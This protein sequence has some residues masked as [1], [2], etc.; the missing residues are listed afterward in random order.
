MKRIAVTAFA[1]LC[2]AGPAAAAPID[3][4]PGPYEAKY[5]NVEGF[6]TTAGT[7]CLT[8]TTDCEN[9]GVLEL[10][11][12][13]P[14]PILGQ[15]PWFELSTSGEITAYFYDIA[16]DQII[17]GP[18]G[19]D[20]GTDPDSFTVNSTGGFLDIYWDDTEDFNGSVA[21]VTDGTLMVRFAF[22]PG[23]LP[24][25]L[26][27]VSGSVN[28]LTSPLSG[29][30]SAYLAVVAGSGPWAAFFDG[31]AIP[32]Q[33]GAPAGADAYSISNF[34]S[35]GVG[36][37]PAGQPW[38]LVSND[39]VLGTIRQVPEPGSLLLLGT[40]LLALGGFGRRRFAR[41]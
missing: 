20:P 38:T 30:A 37:C 6:F 3:L 25:T 4:V 8:I 39:P 29:Q 15:S 14:W 12:I 34:R 5:T 11:T 27:T 24:G 13:T 7:P 1:L 10:T 21:S 33:P 22:V 26:Y 9:E 16:V 31:N 36:E 17:A 18:D 2:V 40:G 23:V 41:K 32:G 35:C 19:P 28:T